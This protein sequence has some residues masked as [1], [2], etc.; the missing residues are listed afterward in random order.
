MQVSRIRGHL[1]IQRGG[2][3][4]GDTPSF[5][6]SESFLKV[7]NI[8]FVK[9]ESFYRSLSLAIGGGG[10]GGGGGGVKVNINLYRPINIGLGYTTIINIILSV[11]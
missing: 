2:L 10:G 6:I 4:L 11:L 1:G 9:N 8:N 7:H 5:I 3:S